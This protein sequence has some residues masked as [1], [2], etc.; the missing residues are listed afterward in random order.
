VNLPDE[1][2]TVVLSSPDVHYYTFSLALS[3]A[4]SSFAR[5]AST[6]YPVADSGRTV[7]ASPARTA[8]P[9]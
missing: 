7:T 1:N 3:Q 9:P 8:F 5:R 6:T 4:N 2:I